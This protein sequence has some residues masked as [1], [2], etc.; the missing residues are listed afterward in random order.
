MAGGSPPKTRGL[1]MTNVDLKDAGTAGGVSE[2]PRLL[3]GTVFLDASP[4]QQRWFDLQQRYLSRTTGRF[5]HVTFMSD[6]SD[7]EVF[8]G[9]TKI[10]RS[11]QPAKTSHFA[12]VY[13]LERLLG[14]FRSCADQYDYFLFLDSDAFPVR[15]QWLDILAERMRSGPAYEIAVALRPEN[16]EVRLHASVLLASR[17]ALAHLDFGVALVGSDLV[18]NPEQDVAMSA[19]QGERR[20]RAFPLLR[21][22]RVNLHPLLCGIYYDLFYHN[23]CGSGRQFV[24][25]AQEYWNHMVDEQVDPEIWIGELMNDPDAFISQL[26]DKT[27]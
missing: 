3:V 22:N 17:E 12:H 2:P 16:L 7:P 11:D 1:K 20:H 27:I 19:Y 15:A 23:G 5:D 26:K 6:G 4:A 13:G 14:Y 8:S 25:R 9:R 10:L 21:S 18:G 24:M